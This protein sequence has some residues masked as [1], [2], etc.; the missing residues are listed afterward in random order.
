MD[1]SDVNIQKK[2]C[3]IINKSLPGYKHIIINPQPDDSIKWAN[4]TFSCEYGSIV[5]NWKKERGT[6]H[7][8]VEIP[9]NTTA[10]V[11]IPDGTVRKIGSGKYTFICSIKR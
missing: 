6:F 5:S 9:C 2:G 7:F 10:D 8:E 1:A 11:V 3:V 4:R